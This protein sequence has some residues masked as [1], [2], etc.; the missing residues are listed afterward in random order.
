M[1]IEYESGVVD[2]QTGDGEMNF[3][4][5]NMKKIVP[6]RCSINVLS[7]YK[8]VE[9]ALKVVTDVVCIR[10]SAFMSA[11]SR[12]PAFESAL[13]AEMSS[14]SSAMKTGLGDAI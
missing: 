7:Q 10:F 5:D 11:H 14:A 4:N 2:G 1:L 8:R 3:G 6:S 9:H 12:S 13:M